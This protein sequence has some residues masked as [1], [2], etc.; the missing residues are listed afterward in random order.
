MT[1]RLSEAQRQEA[2]LYLLND[3][4][5]LAALGCGVSFEEYA[6]RIVKPEN[7]IDQ[8]DDQAHMFGELGRYADFGRASLQ[9]KALQA[10]QRVEQL[11]QEL[12]K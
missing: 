6:R 12:G 2:A 11:R 10:K 7:P 4:Q 1:N 3:D 5:A 9:E 8:A